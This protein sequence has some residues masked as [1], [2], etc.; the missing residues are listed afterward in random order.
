MLTRLTSSSMGAFM[1]SASPADVTLARNTFC[2]VRGELIIS[3]S[4]AD[5]TLPLVCNDGA[6]DCGVVLWFVINSLSC[7]CSF[8]FAGDDRSNCSKCRT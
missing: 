6:C 4:P 5:A 7:C 8:C 1:A 3:K 2:A